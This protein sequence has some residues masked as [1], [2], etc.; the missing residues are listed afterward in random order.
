MDKQQVLEHQK[1]SK[2]FKKE[3]KIKTFLNKPS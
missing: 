3:K 1:N 2:I